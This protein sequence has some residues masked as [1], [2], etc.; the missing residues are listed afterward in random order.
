MDAE[1]GERSLV[2]FMK[3]G[4]KICIP[5]VELPKITFD[6]TVMR[7]GDGDYQL[8]YVQKWMIGDPETVG[9]ED[10]ITI[11]PKEKGVQAKLFNAAGIEMPVALKTNANGQLLFDL[12]SLPQGVYVIQ[13]GK[14]T[15][16]VTRR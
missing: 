14:E 1:N 16:K 4:T 3:S 2:V 6:G 15:L 13:I 7:I 5:I 8:D 9:I 10:V 11:T 12:R